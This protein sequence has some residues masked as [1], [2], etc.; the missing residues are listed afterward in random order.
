MTR[1]VQDLRFKASPADSVALAQKLVDFDLFRRLPADPCGLG[2]QHAIQLQIVGVDSHGRSGRLLDAPQSSDVIDVRVRDDDG[3]NTQFV[4]MDDLDDPLGV[5]ARINYQ[6][7][8]SFW[9]AD[10][11][12]IA[13]QHS[14]RKYF[15]NE[16]G[17]F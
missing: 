4:T 5:I 3:G 10:N 7:V 6:S 1:R 15:V 8:A 2:V 12:A 16:F 17:C 13:L 14:N 9:I 11:M